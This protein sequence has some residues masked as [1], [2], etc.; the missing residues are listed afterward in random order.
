MNYNPTEYT[1]LLTPLHLEIVLHYY[2]RTID[3]ENSNA[4]ATSEYVKHL[5]REGILE[6]TNGHGPTSYKVSAK[7]E[8]WLMSLL[9]VPFPYQSWN[10]QWPR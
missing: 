9:S 4:P 3:M 1:P 5:L 2:S 6:D 8:Y 10:I 7:G